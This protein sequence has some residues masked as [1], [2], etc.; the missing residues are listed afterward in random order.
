MSH[1]DESNL[2]SG[3]KGK[4]PIDDYVDLDM[5]IPRSQAQAAPLGYPG[6]L[7]LYEMEGYV[8]Q[9]LELLAS[10]PTSQYYG[11]E[12]A[13]SELESPT[14]SANR[15]PSGNF[16]PRRKYSQDQSFCKNVALSFHAVPVLN[17][18]RRVRRDSVDCFFGTKSANDWFGTSL[19][20]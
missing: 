6:N 10:T 15:T 5:P 9:S 7:E 16:L 11:P 19:S 13:Y 12:V 3:N 14:R 4:D 17:E 8:L 1:L 20:R 2:G 18:A